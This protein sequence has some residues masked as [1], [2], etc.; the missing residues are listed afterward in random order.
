MNHMA[1]DDR[2]IKSTCRKTE[3]YFVRSK[4]TKNQ[5][6]V[7]YLSAEFKE[8]TKYAYFLWLRLSS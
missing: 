7:A 3:A 2:L 4:K 5:S 6:I 1:Y 8:L